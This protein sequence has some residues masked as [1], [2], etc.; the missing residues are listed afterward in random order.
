MGSI[1]RGAVSLFRWFGRLSRSAFQ[2]PQTRLQGSARNGSA[3]A[4]EESRTEGTVHS[5]ASRKFTPKNGTHPPERVT[6]DFKWGWAAF[7]MVAAALAGASAGARAGRSSTDGTSGRL[8]SGSALAS[9]LPQSRSLAVVPDQPE[10]VDTEGEGGEA[11]VQPGS[12]RGVPSHRSLIQ[13]PNACA[14]QQC[15][16][17][18]FPGKIYFCQK[19][20]FVMR[21]YRQEIHRKSKANDS[22]FG[23]RGYKEIN[24]STSLPDNM[25]FNASDGSSLDTGKPKHVEEMNTF[26][27]VYAPLGAATKG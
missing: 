12:N 5:N 7:S 24:H 27:N 15:R 17:L 4:V 2:G 23:V 21:I 1:F 14:K 10:S 11:A 20:R 13:C 25:R 8:R 3:A 9:F 6:G 16:V 22:R 18:S 26:R 19:K